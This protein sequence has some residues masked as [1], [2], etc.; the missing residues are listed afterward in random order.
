MVRKI[1]SILRPLSN[2]EKNFF[3]ILLIDFFSP[4]NNIENRKL[5]NLPINESMLQLTF[6]NFLNYLRKKYNI[7]NAY[8]YMN[9]LKKL[10][11]RLENE[12][13]LINMGIQPGS[14]P[15][16]GFSYYSMPELTIVQRNHENFFLGKVLGIEYLRE[17]YSQYI[18]RI[19]GEHKTNNISATG[20]GIL[21]NKNTILTCAHNIND[22]KEHS[23][24]INEK[25]L[26]I[27][28][29]KA[30]SKHDIGIIKIEDYNEVSIFP[31]FGT[32]KELDK[33]L[34]LGYPPLTCMKDAALVAQ[35]GEINA[36]AKDWKDAEN[37]I[38]SSITRPGNSGGPVISEE[39]FIVGIVINAGYSVTQIDSEKEVK[40][41]EFST[42]FYNAI[43][44][45]EIIKAL[46][47]LDSELE[48]IFEDYKV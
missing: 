26:Q 16:L 39:G 1:E 30:H 36:I 33:T 38:I 9:A 8:D 22:I 32:P 20:S 7:E 3:T 28:D 6:G 5:L 24:W 10:I 13:L 46:K 4:M 29:M 2:E 48:I 12:G 15:T 43:S 14:G 21:I 17:L 47:E 40:T 19:E 27:K 11:F 31:Y 41:K 34:T 37:I 45:N 35:S 44:S 42:P 23:I 18:V 25:E